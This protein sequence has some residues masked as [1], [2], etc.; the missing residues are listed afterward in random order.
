MPPL[1]TM[2]AT[3]YSQSSEAEEHKRA[4]Q[5]EPQ[6]LPEWSAHDHDECCAFVVPN[7]VAVGCDDA[8][9]V[10]ARR[11]VREISHATRADLNPIDIE[12]FELMLEFDLF[13]FDG[14]QSGV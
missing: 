7:T 11:Q 13:G 12:S 9:R 2:H 6:L 4:Q 8:E 3:P 5:P 1:Q 14:A 10:T